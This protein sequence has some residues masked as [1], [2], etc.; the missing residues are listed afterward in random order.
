MCV[1]THLVQ[2]QRYIYREKC[3]LQSPRNE[4]S[5]KLFSSVGP[6]IHTC[7]TLKK[8]TS[9]T[10]YLIFFPQNNHVYMDNVP[11][12]QDPPSLFREAEY[13][14]WRLSHLSKLLP[15]VG[16]GVK[17]TLTSESRLSP[18]SL[19]LLLSLP[20]H[21]FCKEIYLLISSIMNIF[22]R[23][24]NSFIQVITLDHYFSY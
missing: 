5:I 11:I 1:W 13:S 3:V 6:C 14:I 20:A 24:K 7:S 19:Y 10:S 4:A 18:A 23:N 16:A 8:N 21:I 12:C 2:N 17:L 15:L 9:W 22:F